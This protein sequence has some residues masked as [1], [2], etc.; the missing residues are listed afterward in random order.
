[1]GPSVVLAFSRR[2]KFLVPNG[3]RT[4]DSHWALRYSWYRYTAK[5]RRY[6]AAQVF[7]YTL[8]F[9]LPLFSH[10]TSPCTYSSIFSL[11]L[12]SRRTSWLKQ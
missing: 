10:F 8:L 1:V 9:F 3:I 4:L 5:V 2:E 12:F 7:R 11:F 6:S